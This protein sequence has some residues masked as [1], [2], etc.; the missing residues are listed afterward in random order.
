M[1]MLRSTIAAALGCA[2]AACSSV[3]VRTCEVE[4]L[5]GSDAKT[6][7]WVDDRVPVASDG[8][9]VL[10]ESVV[11]EF[12]TA[13][14]ASLAARGYERVEVSD[15]ALE[16]TLHVGLSRDVRRNDP[17]FA[18]YPWEQVERAHLTFALAD[19][20]DG[21]VVW[22][23]SGERELRVTDRGTGHSE[24]H[25]VGTEEPRAWKAE[26]MANAVLG[27]LPKR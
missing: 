19:V 23:A 8:Q 12:R 11:E 10:D 4:T 25:Y 24:I 21:A 2:L 16:A 5:T 17:Y 1:L 15:A 6:Y 20:R 9:P 18:F 7:A 22:S 26:R 27:D 13:L 3:D 14:D